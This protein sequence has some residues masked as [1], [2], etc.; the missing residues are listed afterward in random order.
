MPHD[1]DRG[2]RAYFSEFT[3]PSV[4]LSVV[5]IQRAKSNEHLSRNHKSKQTKLS[6][7]STGCVHN[8]PKA[9]STQ[10][11]RD[12]KSPKFAASHAPSAEATDP[13]LRLEFELEL[14]EHL[15]RRLRK[16]AHDAITLPSSVKFSVTGDTPNKQPEL[17]FACPSATTMSRPKSPKSKEPQQLEGLEQLL[18]NIREQLVSR[19]TR[20]CQ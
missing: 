5:S 8:L 7:I 3:A 14:E 9:S 2:G 19:L 6:V 13:K 18:H 17:A 10:D 1:R 11:L 20:V 12:R 15:Q 16:V 4:S